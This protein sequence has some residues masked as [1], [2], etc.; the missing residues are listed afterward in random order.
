V[1][2]TDIFLYILMFGFND[3]FKSILKLK[4]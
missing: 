4:Y 1:N 3:L 2:A